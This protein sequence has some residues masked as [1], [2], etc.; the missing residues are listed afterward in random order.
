M[1]IYDMWYGYLGNWPSLLSC[2]PFF[3]TLVGLANALVWTASAVSGGA[4]G[5]TTEENFASYGLA[6]LPLVLSGFMVYHLYYLI[7]VGVYFPIVLWQ[8]FQFEIFRQLVVTVPPFWTHAMQ[9]TIVWVGLFGTLAIGFRLSRGRHTD[10]FKAAH[11]FL[12]HAT[13][14]VFFA[15]AL[16]KAVHHFFY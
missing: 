2:S 9:T 14:A 3:L 13:I 5:E 7:H 4:S 1:P 10:G 12:P 15:L 8:T 16:L 6:L 11:E